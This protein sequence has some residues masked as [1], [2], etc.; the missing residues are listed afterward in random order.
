MVLNF[1]TSCVDENK[2][3]KHR[4]NLNRAKRDQ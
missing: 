1:Q 2:L 3:P 4:T